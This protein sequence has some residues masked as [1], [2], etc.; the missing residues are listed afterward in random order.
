MEKDTDRGTRED[1]RITSCSVGVASG[2]SIFLFSFYAS[3]LQKR[4][5]SLLIYGLQNVKSSICITNIS[6]TTAIVA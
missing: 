1:D 6:K 5:F 2:S 4:L 3:S